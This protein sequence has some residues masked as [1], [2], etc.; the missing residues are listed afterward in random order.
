MICCCTSI[1]ILSQTSPLS[2]GEQR[3]KVA[4]S[5]AL[6]SMSYFS[7]NEKL[8]QATKSAWSIRYGERIGRLPKRRWEVVTLPAF[9]ES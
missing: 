1:G 3:R 6:E 2:K 4:P 7:R 9:F 5:L 8:W